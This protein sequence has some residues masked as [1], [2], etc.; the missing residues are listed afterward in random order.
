MKLRLASSLL[1]CAY[2]GQCLG[3]RPHWYVGT[4]RTGILASR[5][6]TCWK[7]L[8]SCVACHSVETQIVPLVGSRGALLVCAVLSSHIDMQGL[9]FSFHLYMLASPLHARIAIPALARHSTQCCHGMPLDAQSRVC[10]DHRR[11]ITPF[12]APW[13]KAMHVTQRHTLATDPGLSD[14]QQH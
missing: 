11:A 14:A 7:H 3:G 5:H 2:T 10:V 4:A 12:A 9:N 13:R 6:A 8:C 1:A